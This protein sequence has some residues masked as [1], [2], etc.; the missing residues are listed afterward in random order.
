MRADPGCKRSSY[1]VVPYDSSVPR[2]AWQDRS[3]YDRSTIRELSRQA[4]SGV[5]L[6]QYRT[7]HSRLVGHSGV[8]TRWSWTCCWASTEAKSASP[9]SS[10][11]R[12]SPTSSTFACEEW[13]KWEFG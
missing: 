11:A 9:T 5:Q 6:G 3:I 2:T 8:H 10:T 1:L 7:W 4:E 13:D 12:A